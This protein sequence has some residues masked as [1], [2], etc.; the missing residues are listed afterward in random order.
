VTIYG[1]DESYASPWFDD[2][3]YDLTCDNCEARIADGWMVGNHIQ[4]FCSLVCVEA[5]G[6]APAD[7]TRTDLTLD[8]E[9]D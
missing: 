9:G 1:E 5:A 8:P 6:V 7:V 4:T 2:P 3:D